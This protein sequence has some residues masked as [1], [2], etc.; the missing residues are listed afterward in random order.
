MLIMC[1]YYAYTLTKMILTCT[2]NYVFNHLVCKLFNKLCYLPNNLRYLCN[3][4]FY[5]RLNTTT[6]LAICSES[7]AGTTCWNWKR[8]LPLKL[9][10]SL[11]LLCQQTQSI[12]INMNNLIV[13]CTLYFY[14]QL[15][16]FRVYVPE[17]LL[18]SHQIQIY[19]SFR[20]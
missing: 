16:R 5:S 1:A 10:M 6:R 14:V 20:P 3:R 9:N 15:F 8:T 13:S 19:P 12:T 4:L 7:W 17:N 2:F 11:F 18:I